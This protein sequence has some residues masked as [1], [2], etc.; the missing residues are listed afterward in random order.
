LL[1]NKIMD[2]HDLRMPQTSKRL[3]LG[4]KLGDIRVPKLCPQ[5][6]DRCV[7]FQMEV[8]TQIDRGLPTLPKQTH[9]P[10]ITENLSNTICHKNLPKWHN[11]S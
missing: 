3:S 9:Q 7:T 4:Q 10:I 2:R 8:L 6:F 1:D 11:W 5:D